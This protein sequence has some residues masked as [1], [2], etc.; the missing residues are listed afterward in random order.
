MY[1]YEEQ[2]ASVFE[3]ENQLLFLKIRDQ[4]FDKL[5]SSGSITMG[6]AIALPRGIGAAESWTIMACVDRLCELGEI[7]EILT[8]GMGQDRIFIKTEPWK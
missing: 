1:K 6:A 7:K 3:E 2:R 4:I 5:K 8:N